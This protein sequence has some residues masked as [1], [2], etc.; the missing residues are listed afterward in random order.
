MVN[1][2]S[3]GSAP[4]ALVVEDDPDAAEVAAGMLRLLGY[5]AR[6]ANDGTTALQMLTQSKPD[7]MLLDVC[8]P[9]MDGMMLMQV[10]GRFAD[11][12]DVPIVAASAV[13]SP[14]G[15]EARVLRQLGV[16]HVMAKPFSLAG[17]RS[18]VHQIDP[19]RDLPS[20]PRPEEEAKPPEA[21]RPR[22]K[23]RSSISAES[24]D[25]FGR[26]CWGSEEATCFVERLIGQD[27][28]IR[29]TGGQPDV[30]VPIE[31]EVADRATVDGVQV[32]SAL[33][34]RGE[35]FKVKGAPPGSRVRIQIRAADPGEAWDR[36]M[37]TMKG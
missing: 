18:I 6:I 24:Y 14:E 26:A 19:G 8:L 13:Y 4:I 35:V 10:A 29:T 31:V 11:L 23:A 16:K 5:H 32:V 20:L 27:L 12:N 15:T 25:L 36:L 21:I 30:G 37:A 9:S 28:L 17:L 33:R 3:N 34:I 2:P 7:L 1:P 22:R